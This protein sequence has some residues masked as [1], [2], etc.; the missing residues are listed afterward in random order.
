MDHFCFFFIVSLQAVV[1][2][3][4]ERVGLCFFVSFFG[5]KKVLPYSPKEPCY[6]AVETM[7]LLNDDSP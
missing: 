4:S 3:L 1:G 2:H 7:A 5:L 6:G